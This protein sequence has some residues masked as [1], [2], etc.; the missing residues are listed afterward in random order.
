M[1]SPKLVPLRCQAGKIRPEPEVD[2]QPET[3]G[4]VADRDQEQEKE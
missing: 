2:G 4:Q 3:E 1:G